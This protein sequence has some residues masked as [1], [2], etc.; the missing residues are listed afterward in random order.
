LIKKWKFLSK[1]FDQGFQIFYPKEM[2]ISLGQ[3]TGSQGF[4]FE[5]MT[6]IARA[7]T[8]KLSVSP[9]TRHLTRVIAFEQCF[10]R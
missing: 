9:P 7:Q 10:A 8:F 4:W 5:T 3:Q 2:K 6:E 1:R